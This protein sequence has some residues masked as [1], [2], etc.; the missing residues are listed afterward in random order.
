MKASD[1]GIALVKE[2]EGLATESYL[3][4]GGKV[5]WGYGHLCK[6]GEI[7]PRYISE[8]DATTLLCSDMEIAEACVTGCVDVPLTQGQFDALCSF[9]F[10]L[11]CAKL[12]GSTLLRILNGGDYAGAA[13]EFQKWCRVG[14]NQ[15]PGLLRRRLAEQALFNGP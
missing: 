4:I 3:D 10:N 11:G 12:K 6:T 1:R 7:P 5:T 13:R 15:V 14:Q 8:G 2:F 9:V